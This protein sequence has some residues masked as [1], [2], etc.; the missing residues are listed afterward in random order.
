MPTLRPAHLGIVAAALAVAGLVLAATGVV[1]A[2]VV[3]GLAGPVLVVVVVLAALSGP[4]PRPPRP[5]SARTVGR[6]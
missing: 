5:R 3:A 2:P 4:A 6:R 1:D